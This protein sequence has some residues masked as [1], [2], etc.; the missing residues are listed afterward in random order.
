MAIR[1]LEDGDDRLYE[2]VPCPG[3]PIGGKRHTEQT[4][5]VKE[6]Y[7][8]RTKEDQL[9]RNMQAIKRRSLILEPSGKTYGTGNCARYRV[10]QNG[11][12]RILEYKKNCKLHISDYSFSSFITSGTQCGIAFGVTVCCGNWSG[13]SS[14]DIW[15]TDTVWQNQDLVWS[16]PQCYH[17]GTY[18]CGVAYKFGSAGGPIDALLQGVTYEF[19]VVAWDANASGN[20]C[21]DPT[22]G[23]GSTADAIVHFPFVAGNQPF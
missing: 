21:K 8:P 2:C 13:S 6:D 15:V 5:R 12:R 11:Q 14:C 7:Y 3:G 16:D 10:L 20:Q 18:G 17:L 9:S 19:W 23:P 4:R 1:L 22:T